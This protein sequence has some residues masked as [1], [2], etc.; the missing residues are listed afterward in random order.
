LALGEASPKEHPRNGAVTE[1]KNEA[2]AQKD[3]FNLSSDPVAR[4]HLFLIRSSN[5]VV[6]DSVELI[7]SILRGH[8]QRLDIVG[9]ADFQ[10]HGTAV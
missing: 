3:R 2:Q 8:F 1:A 10:E 5:L 9:H 4:L 6:R 7:F